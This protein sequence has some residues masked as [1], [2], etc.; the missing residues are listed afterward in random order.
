MIAD[1]II[2]M[3]RDKVFSSFII[4]LIG[5]E[6]SIPST[7]KSKSINFM[8]SSKQYSTPLKKDKN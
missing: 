6:W 1:I 8:R 3:K 2:D 5:T 4:E 7:P